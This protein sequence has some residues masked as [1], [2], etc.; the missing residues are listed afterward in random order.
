MSDHYDIEE[1]TSPSRQRST[2]NFPFDKLQPSTKLRN[3]DLQGPSFFVPDEEASIIR[4]RSASQNAAYK[5]GCAFSVRMDTREGV[6]GCRVWRC[7]DPE[8]NS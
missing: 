2:F 5:L 3:G 7:P 4:V 1:A 6:K 8:R